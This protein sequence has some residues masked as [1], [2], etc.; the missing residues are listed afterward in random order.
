MP[1][2]RISKVA[3]VLHRAAETHHVVFAKVDGNDDDWASWYSEWLITLSELP[4]LLGVTPVRSE[5]THALVQ[6]DRDHTAHE[7]TEP[8]EPYYAQ[9][10]VDR[11][12]A[13]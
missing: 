8:W 9:G 1:D 6:L 5:L 4:E 3:D 2:D 13:T 12:S 7:P 10:L 11:F